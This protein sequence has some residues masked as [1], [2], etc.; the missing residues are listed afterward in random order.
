MFWKSTG[1]QFVQLVHCWFDPTASEKGTFIKLQ[2]AS[3]LI[4]K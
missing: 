3:I 2:L 4:K 1:I